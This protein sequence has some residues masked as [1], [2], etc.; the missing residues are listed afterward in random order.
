MVEESIFHEPQQ[1]SIIIIIIA[2]VGV[3]LAQ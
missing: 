3:D 2:W 1:I